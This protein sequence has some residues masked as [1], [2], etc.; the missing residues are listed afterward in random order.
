[1]VEYFIKKIENAPR[2]SKTQKISVCE[3][4]T[5]YFKGSGLIRDVQISGIDFEK[6]NL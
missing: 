4:E 5:A 3:D 6:E 2:D 1:M